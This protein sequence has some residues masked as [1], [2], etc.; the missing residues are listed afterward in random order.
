MLE[1]V[2]EELAELRAAVSKQQAAAI[3]DELGDLLFSVSNVARHL[4]VN[5]ELAL[6]NATTKFEQRFRYVEKALAKKGLS[7]ET[8]SEAELDILW[9]AAKK[10]LA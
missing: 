9:N 3:E 4:K 2:E 6:R 5:P 7:M 10:Q 8:A 1:K